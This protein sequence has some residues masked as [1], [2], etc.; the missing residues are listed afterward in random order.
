VGDIGR[1]LFLE[2]STLTPLLKRLEAKGL[3]IR[4]RD[5]N[6]ERQVRI[7]LTAEGHALATPAQCMRDSLIAHLRAENADIDALRRLQSDL[8]KLRTILQAD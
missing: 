2:S 7:H 1:Q 8:N 4:Q 5:Q 6:D 3:V